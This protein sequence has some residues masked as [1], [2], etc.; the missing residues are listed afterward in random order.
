MFTTSRY[1]SIETRKKAS[2]H[3]YYVARGKK[4]I[5]DLAAIARKKGYA[6]IAIVGENKTST[7]AVDE[8]GDWH[9]L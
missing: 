3:G 4:T 1:A 8:M 6:R 9:Y 2:G 5:A 7:I